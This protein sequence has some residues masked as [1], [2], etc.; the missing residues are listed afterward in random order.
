MITEACVENLAHAQLAQAGGADQ[1]ELCGRLDVGGLT[2]DAA[3]VKVTMQS[4][5]IPVKVMIRPRAGIVKLCMVTFTNAA[6]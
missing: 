1:V 4:L 2:P 6:S 3:L 5:T